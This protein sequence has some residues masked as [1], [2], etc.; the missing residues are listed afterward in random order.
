MG[1]WAGDLVSNNKTLQCSI[2]CAGVVG[3]VKYS[4]V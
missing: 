3:V 2:M 1:W 4:K